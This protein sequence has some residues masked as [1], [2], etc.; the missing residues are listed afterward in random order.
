VVLLDLKLPG[1]GGFAVL[2]WIRQQPGL[3]ALR[4]V[5]LTGSTDI[6]D[7]NRAY[8]L[9][10]NS[11]LVK[12]VDFDSFVQVAAALAGYWLWMSKKPEV[13]RVACD[14]GRRDSKS[15]NKS[16]EA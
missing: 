9:G 6:K 1:I 7:V 4:V 8:Q 16:G 2:E 10:S 11:F 5:V 15:A 3:K 13:S 12:P 14:N